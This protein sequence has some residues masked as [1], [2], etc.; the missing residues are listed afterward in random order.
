MSPQAGPLSGAFASTGSE[1]AGAGLGAAAKVE[2]MIAQD[3]G[4]GHPARLPVAELGP[5]GMGHHL[6]RKPNAGSDPRI[7]G[8]VFRQ[9]E[10]F[11]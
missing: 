4:A 7:P 6:R 5:H 1:C 3:P 11:T 8:S 10:G 2:V 9:Q